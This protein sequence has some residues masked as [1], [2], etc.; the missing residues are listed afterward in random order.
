MTQIVAHITR[1]TPFDDL[2]VIARNI[3]RPMLRD[4]LADALAERAH[5]ITDEQLAYVYR[6][7]YYSSFGVVYNYLV[8]RWHEAQ[9]VH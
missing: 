5:E 2:T 7:A 1:H 8:D 3:I 6:D 9:M 4:A